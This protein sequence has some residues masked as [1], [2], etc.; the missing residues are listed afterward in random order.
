MRKLLAILLCTI[1]LVIPASITASAQIDSGLQNVAGGEPYEV[2]VSVGY[3]AYSTYSVT[4][5]ISIRADYPTQ[6]SVDMS[7]F[8]PTYA[9]YCYVSNADESGNVI[10]YAD[11]YSTTG[12]TVPVNFTTSDGRLSGE[13][14]LLYKFRS[15]MGENDPIE[16]CDINVNS[17]NVSRVPAGNY[18]G[19]V[20]LRFVC[21][22]A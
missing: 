1:L 13:T 20:S 17:A 22:E 19:V 5:P 11:N 3:Y 21:Q 2:D 7:N 10:L 14:K 18:S 15:R 4:V 16:V 8:D 6:I 9:L 12:N